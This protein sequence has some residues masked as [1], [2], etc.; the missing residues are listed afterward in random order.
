MKSYFHIKTI[1]NKTKK[2]LYD[3]KKL[4]T[5]LNCGGRIEKSIFDPSR[6]GTGKRLK[7]PRPMFASTIIET[8]YTNPSFAIPEIMP[9]RNII[10]NT[11][12]TAKLASMPADATNSVPHLK[13]V[14][15]RSL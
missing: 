1:K 4:R 8:I 2:R 3:S 10:P 5:F 6:G 13:F 14:K 9:R 15:L 11:I 7:T 12:A